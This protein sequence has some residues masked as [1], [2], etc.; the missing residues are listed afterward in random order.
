M[1]EVKF[2]QRIKW[3]TTKDVH[4]PEKDYWHYWGVIDRRFITPLSIAEFDD[5]PSYQYTGRKDKTGK[6]IWEG[7]KT[8]WPV[9]SDRTYDIVYEDAYFWA[10]SKTSMVPLHEIDTEGKLE[11]IGSIHENPELLEVLK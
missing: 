2:R 7:S 6:E 10:S 8:L 3:V 5:R 9:T 1:R 11:I 4:I